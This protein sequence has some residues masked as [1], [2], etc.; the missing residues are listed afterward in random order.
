M[1]SLTPIRKTFRH[2]G[3]VLTVVS[4]ALTGLFGLTMASNIVMQVVIAVG[5]M[6][7]TVASAYVWPFVA[8]AFQARRRATACVL[9]AFG[10][11]VTG[12]DLTTNFGSIAWQR[13]LDVTEAKVSQTKWSDARD[14][15][16]EGKTNLELWRKR[17]ET[18]EAQ[19]AWSATVTADALRAQLAGANL[20]I[21]L[22]AK[23][24]GCKA[25]CLER[26]KERDD[27]A[28]KIAIAE[29]TGQLRKQIA[30]TK[31]V[32][33]QHREQSAN[34]EK[35]ESAAEMQNVSLASVFTLSLEPTVAAQH[36]TDK[37]VNW[38]VAAFFAF[39]AM[40]CNFLGWHAAKKSDDDTIDPP[41]SA[42]APVTPT[43]NPQTRA[44]QHRALAGIPAEPIHV[45]TTDTIH[46]K[47]ATLRR[48]SLSDE[49]KALLE[50]A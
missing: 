30:A 36:W 15:V 43:H 4:A 46:I 13:S 2:V 3:L 9:A 8:E 39:G 14:N 42:K 31:A 21:D 47:D 19:N 38:M 23:R 12:T 10:M 45:H 33:A 5:L 1:D 27:I 49:V 29:E 18:L 41:P 16:T 32:L 17:L 44:P 25:K 37:G 20:A 48:W 22:E 40:G 6:C 11:L 24:G 28:S 35:K 26:T 34:T 7:A 50:A